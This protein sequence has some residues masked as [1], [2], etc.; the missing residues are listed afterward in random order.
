M[1]VSTKGPG[2]AKIRNRSSVQLFFGAVITIFFAYAVLMM[3]SDSI[4]T[5]RTSSKVA[6]ICYI[7]V[8][9]AGIVLFIKGYKNR[10]LV[11]NFEIYSR[12]L[13][14]DPNKYITM[15]SATTK[16]PF[17]VTKKNIT[18]MLELGFFPGMYIED[19]KNRLIYQ[20]VNQDAK[21]ALQKEEEANYI[22]VKCGGCG[23]VNKLPKGGTGTCEYCG[24]P[25]AAK[26]E[27]QSD[28][29]E[30]AE[31]INKIKIEF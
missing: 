31:V 18:K 26:Q 3:W 8:T 24:S 14:A 7:G 2:V 11:K 21:S 6:T 9:I 30:I 22:E 20:G 27:E 23:A 25:I 17:E 13:G 15:I 10:K 29:A 5:N 1:T 4:V 19:A 16:E 28:L 12:I